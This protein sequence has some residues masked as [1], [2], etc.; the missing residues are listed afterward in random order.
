MFGR[1]KILDFQKVIFFYYES[2]IFCYIKKKQKQVCKYLYFFQI[3]YQYFKDTARNF[4]NLVWIF[5]R[6]YIPW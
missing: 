2:R 4:K 5:F 3:F 6:K 1:Q